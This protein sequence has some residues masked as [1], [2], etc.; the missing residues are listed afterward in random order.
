MDVLS[1]VSVGGPLVVLHPVRS[2]SVTDAERVASRSSRAP[3]SLVRTSSTMAM[4]SFHLIDTT[5][6]DENV[7]GGSELAVE[8]SLPARI[9]RTTLR[10]RCHR[11]SVYGRME[12]TDSH[13]F[14]DASTVVRLH[15]DRSVHVGFRASS[16]RL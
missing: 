1:F 14:R 11:R 16:A 3:R 7:S 12:S 2:R 10:T 5:D 8:D 15:C 9:S 4:K 13:R 6:V